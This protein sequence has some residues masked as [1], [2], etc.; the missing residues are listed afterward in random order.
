MDMKILITG[1]NG[2]V[3]RNLTARLLE[4]PKFK[5]LT[6]DSNHEVSHLSKILPEVNFVIHLAG[7]NRPK[8]ED[9]F[10]KNNVELTKFIC[11]EISKQN[12]NIPLI[13]SSSIHSS[14]NNSYG[15]SKKEAEKIIENYSI[16][17]NNPVIIY[18]FPGIFGKW[19]KPNFNSVVATFCHNIANN[20]PISII[21]PNKELSLI[22]ID[23]VIDELINTINNH[24]FGVNYRRVSPEYKITI[25]DLAKKIQCFKD[26]RINLHVDQVGCGITRALY[27]TYLSYIPASQF[28][29]PVPYHA[30]D[31][32]LFVPLLKTIDSGQ[33]SFLTAKPGITRG[34]HY[35]NTKIEKFLVVKGSA[36]FRF[37][38]ILSREIFTITTSSEY[39]E[40]VETIPGWAHDITNIGK[41]EMIALLWANEIFDKEKPD[42]YKYQMDI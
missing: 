30:D 35:H 2:F 10:K 13:F 12:K 18:K 36:K 33:I 15:K 20:L 27:A 41:E 3:G 19:C 38:N 39:P 1:A 31:R 40:I 14:S 26:G 23:D 37:I 24:N 29:Y 25:G 5:V 42:T 21:D 22:Y 11:D 4:N 16:N 34:G 28:S 9:E 6:F 8:N 7:S 32:G 17:T